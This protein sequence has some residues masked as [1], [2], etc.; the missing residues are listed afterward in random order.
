M[1]ITLGGVPLN[2][3]MIWLERSQSSRVAQDVA[4]TLGGVPVV[5]SAALE[6]G[7]S[8]TLQATTDTGWLT[9]GALD[10]VMA[11]ANVPGG[12]YSLDYNGETMDVMFRHNDAPAVDFTPL[13]DRPTHDMTD[14]FIGLIKLIK[15]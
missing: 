6:G 13:I 5:S 1:S 15:V 7:N 4:L 8:V 3:Q 2:Q 14:F 11:L 12:V 9:K 10:Q